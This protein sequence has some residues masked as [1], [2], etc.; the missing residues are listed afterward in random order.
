[1]RI[2]CTK[3]L[4]QMSHRTVENSHPRRAKREAEKQI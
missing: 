2:T 4:P 3:R 1:M